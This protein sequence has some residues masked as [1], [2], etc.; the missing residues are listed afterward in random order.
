M[1]LAEFEIQTNKK[2]ARD[3]FEMT[4]CGN[5]E[6]ITVPGSFVNVKLDGFFLRRP[7]SVCDVQDGVLTLI[8]KTVGGGTEQMSTYP[9]GKRLSLL[10]GLGNGFDVSLSGENPLLVAGGVG[11]P[12]MYLLAKRLIGQGKTVSVALGFN[13][14]KDVFLADRLERL[15]AAVG[16]ATV[17]GSMGKKGFVTDI[18]PQSYSY[19]YA[20]GPEPMLRAVYRATAGEG[21]L[22]FEERMGCGFGACMGCTCKTL[23]GNKRICKDG[24][25]LKKSEVIF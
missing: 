4:L 3:V 9:A 10:T 13:S 14:V 1:K 12:P 18:L 21:E 16:I 5:T 24:P 15:G 2:I 20:C 8:Y 22:S 6:D 17:D 19:F 7:I 25:V 23:A 11:A